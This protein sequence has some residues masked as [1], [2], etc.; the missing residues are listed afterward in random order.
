[1][2]FPAVLLGI[3]LVCCL[4]IA[5]YIHNKR[6]HEIHLSKQ[7]SFLDIKFRVT[8]DVLGE[9]QEQ[10]AQSTSLLEKTKKEVE[11]VTK[12]LSDAKTLLEN[13]KSELETCDTDK[14]RMTLE[15]NVAKSEKTSVQSEFL[16]EKVRW[17][18]E[19]GFLK[20][21]LEGR[22]K[23]CKY[24]DIYS[25]EARSLCGIVGE[26]PKPKVE[27]PKPEAPK[28]EQP[29]P[30]APKA[31]EPKPEAPK[32]E[33]PQP[34]APKAEQ[35]KPEAPK[36]EPP[37]PEAPKAEQPQPEA[38][39]VEQPKPEAPKVE[40]PKPE[41]PKVEQPKPEEPKVEQPKPEEPQVKAS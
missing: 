39:K 40:P 22:S 17:S 9:Y 33:Q 12:E 18:D 27:E 7:A 1:M 31:E 15:G 13:K 37:K 16:R 5:G 10:L 2:K 41:E 25:E 30:E 14:K 19:V 35:P 8:R 3:A 38:P 23:L 24:I 26:P 34:E 6:K 20:K 21:E 11:D 28:A 36:A 32:A 4:G 29:K